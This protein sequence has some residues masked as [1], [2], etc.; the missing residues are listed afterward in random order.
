MTQSYTS[1]P[2]GRSPGLP[3]PELR[4]EFYEGLA[5]K[6]FMAWLVDLLL[7]GILVALVVLFTIGIGLFFLPV[8]WAV[9]DFCY[10]V[11][12]LSGKGATPG[13]RLMGIEFRDRLGHRVNF[14]ASVLLTLGYLVSTGFIIPQLISAVMVMVSPRAQSLTDVVLGTAAINRPARDW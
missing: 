10:R 2:A 3:D 5:F 7:V 12:A 6:R 11:I 14:G 8:I 4:P 1:A 13:H 9:I